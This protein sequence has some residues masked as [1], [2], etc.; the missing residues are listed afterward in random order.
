MLNVRHTPMSFCTSMRVGVQVA[1][2]SRQQSLSQDKQMLAEAT[3]SKLQEWLS[4]LQKDAPA[5]S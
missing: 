3:I 2:S 4:E 5:T 1:Q